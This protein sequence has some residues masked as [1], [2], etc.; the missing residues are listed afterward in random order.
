VNTPSPYDQLLAAK[1]NQVPV[2]DMADSIWTTINVQLD[3]PVDVPGKKPFQQFKGKGWYGLLGTVTVVALL[4]WGY[5]HM[6]HTPPNTPSQKILPATKDS[7]VAA[8]SNTIVNPVKEKNNIVK[9]VT[10][11]K[12]SLQRQRTPNKS[13]VVDSALKQYVL[14]QP[15]DSSLFHINS[16]P[17]PHVVDSVSSRPTGKRPKGIKGISSDDYKITATKDSGRKQ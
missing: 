3:A 1:L 6:H 4:W 10:V 2:P 9:P 12:D 11:K 15:I 7:S 8:D 5:K 13:A 16:T 17:L 14:P